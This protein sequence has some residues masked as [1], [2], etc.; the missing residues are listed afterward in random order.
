METS[1]CSTSRKIVDTVTE[2]VK[3]GDDFVVFE[4]GRLVG[5]WLGEVADER[6]GWIA[7]SA[8]LLEE[9][10]LQRK[11]GCVRVLAITGVKV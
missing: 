8:I 1:V 11:V 7:A 9:A 4:E 5:C 2:F 3:E 10:R 6:G